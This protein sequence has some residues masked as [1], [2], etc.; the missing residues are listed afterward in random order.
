MVGGERHRN[1]YGEHAAYD[2]PIFHSSHPPIQSSLILMILGDWPC[3][4]VTDT[5]PRYDSQQSQGATEH[6][7]HPTA[8]ASAPSLS[9]VLMLFPFCIPSL[10]QTFFFCYLYVSFPGPLFV[11]LSQSHFVVRVLCRFSCVCKCKGR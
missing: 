1:N 3:V 8:D 2:T 5:I 4:C 11:F 7:R 9:L 6:S 10:F